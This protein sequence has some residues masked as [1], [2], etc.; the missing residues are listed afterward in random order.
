[1]RLIDT[2]TAAYALGCSRRQIQVL[3]AEGKLTNHG[4]PRRISVDLDELY[5]RRMV[6]VPPRQCDLSGGVTD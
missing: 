3:V 2:E 5:D 4:A 1:M 6:L